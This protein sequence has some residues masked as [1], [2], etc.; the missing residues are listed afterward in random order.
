MEEQSLKAQQGEIEFRKKLAKQHVEGEQI[1]SD[2][3]T[4]KQMEMILKERMQVTHDRMVALKNRKICLSPYIEFGAERC[5]RSLVMENDFG[6]RGASVDISYDMLKSCEHYAGI[7]NCHNKPIRVCC[8]IK[9]LPF[10]S[11][12]VPFAFCYQTLHHFPDPG[13]VLK[14]VFRVLSIGGHLFFDEEPYKKVLHLNLYDRKIYAKETLKAS[15]LRR[16]VDYFFANFINNETGYGIVEN[17]IIALKDWK[18]STVF[19]R[20]KGSADNNNTEN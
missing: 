10:R 4:L 17:D 12:S 3:F 13:E 14:E 8:D 5:Q 6:A 15:R 16:V 20:K 18:K 1:F 9:F 11:N 19:I 2:E 7:F